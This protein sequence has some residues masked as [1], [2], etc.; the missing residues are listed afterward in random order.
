MSERMRALF[1][2]K[3]WQRM[4]ARWQNEHVSVPRFQRSGSLKLKPSHDRTSGSGY[5]KD[6]LT[7]DPRAFFAEPYLRTQLSPLNP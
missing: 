3:G 7:D 1:G 5:P 6:E 2:N 4:A